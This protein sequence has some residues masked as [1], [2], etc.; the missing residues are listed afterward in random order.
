MRTLLVT[1]AFFI[2]SLQSFPAWAL[3]TG[4]TVH[5]K[6]L[7]LVCEFCAQAIE[8][9]FMDTGKVESI[10]VDLDKALV[11]IIMKKGQ[12][13]SDDM[14]ATQMKDSGYAVENIHHMKETSHD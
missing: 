11:T 10:D 9:V 13:F 6:A 2:L 3:H 5:V 7:G 14:I 4:E 12:A 8:K 1:A